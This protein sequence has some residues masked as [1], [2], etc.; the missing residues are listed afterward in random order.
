MDLLKHTIIYNNYIT[1]SFL[2]LFNDSDK[3]YKY[4]YS[5][6]RYSFTDI[7]VNYCKVI[8]KK[9]VKMINNY[10]SDYDILQ[11]V[12]NW[13]KNVP[14]KDI[15]GFP[16]SN[17]EYITTKV[18]FMNSVIKQENLENNKNNV[19]L[20]IGAGDCSITNAFG[21]YNNMIPVGID[22][23][24]DID[25]GS[26]GG[27]TCNKIKHIF[28][29]GNDLKEVYKKNFKTKKVGMIMYNHSL[30]HFGSFENI[31]SSLEQSYALL[32]KGGILLIRE[33]NNKSND[34]DINLQHII[35]SLRYTIDHYHKWDYEQ[36]WIYFKNF[37]YTYSSHFFSKEFLINM[38]K[39]IGFK[40]IDAKKN[41]QL[42]Y[43]DYTDISKTYL[44]SFIK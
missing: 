27:N 16:V 40:F 43:V 23:K 11:L 4:T 33:H 7:S 35:L 1:V 3:M 21:K 12:Y 41:K 30:H 42:D 37:I 34:I 17:E 5:L 20:D 19:L 9:L 24:S 6:I 15:I 38:C 25:W 18:K 2:K 39:K 13:Y 29:K 26:A 44:Y 14:K 28:Y 32:Q 10:A 22:I 31:Y 8:T 36:I